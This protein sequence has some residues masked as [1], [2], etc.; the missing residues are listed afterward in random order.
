MLGFDRHAA[1]VT[2]TAA[3]VILLLYLVYLVRTTLFIFI[4]ALLLAYLLSPL[5]NALYRLLPWSRTRAPAMA[6][7]Y[8]LFI[9]LLVF[10]GSQIGSRVVQQAKELGDKLPSMIGSVKTPSPTAPAA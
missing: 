9:G 6:L 3:I 7:A 4:L 10:I 5:V 8:V 2:F 1:R